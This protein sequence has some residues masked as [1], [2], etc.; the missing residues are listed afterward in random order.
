M[1]GEHLPVAKGDGFDRTHR[2]LLDI[3][4]VE[5]GVIYDLVDVDF[6][7]GGCVEEIVMQ[8]KEIYVC[9]AV[10]LEGSKENGGGGRIRRG[11]FGGGYEFLERRN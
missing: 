2:N 7:A 3:K 4:R 9:A 5:K 1:G 6:V 10:G 11:V 8:G